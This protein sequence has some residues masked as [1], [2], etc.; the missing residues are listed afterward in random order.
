MQYCNVSLGNL[1]AAQAN[2]L[3]RSRMI[4]RDIASWV[5][6]YSMVSYLDGDPSLLATIKDKIMDIPLEYINVLRTYFGDAA[7]DKYSNMLLQYVSLLLSIIDAYKSGDVDA[8]NKY[9]REILKNMDERAEYLSKIN[10]FWQKD[11]AKNLIYNFTILLINEAVS[12][13]SKD[14]KMTVALFERV[15]N[16]TTAMGD[17][18][19]EG[20]INYLNYSARTPIVPE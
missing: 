18:V 13:L 15:T 12:F 9:T 16:H 17:F 7:A 10:P 11:I 2:L 3:F 5:G 6:L 1:T 20:L 19:T 8:I 14:F 4:W